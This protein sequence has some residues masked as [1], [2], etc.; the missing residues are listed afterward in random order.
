MFH[1]PL[2]KENWLEKKNEWKLS[3]QSSEAMYASI[4]LTNRRKS[5]FFLVTYLEHGFM[6]A[7][8]VRLNLVVLKILETSQ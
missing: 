1:F 3:N 8:L 6:I 7:N 5:F 2:L 4:C